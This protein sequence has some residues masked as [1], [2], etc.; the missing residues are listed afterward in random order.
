MAHDKGLKS[1][2]FASISTGVYGY[3][4]AEAAGIAIREIID[5]MEAH[6]QPSLVRMVLFDERTFD[7]YAEALRE[8]GN[9]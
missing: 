9:D 1:L 6:D 5:F 7:A 2:A 8:Q 4:V 3:P